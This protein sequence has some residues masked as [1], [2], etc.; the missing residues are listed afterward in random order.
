MVIINNQST[1]IEQ[2]L[3]QISNMLI[4]NGILVN[5]PG[6]LHGKT[7]VAVFFFHYAQYTGNGLFEDYALDLIV[8]IQEQI[9]LNN[10]ADYERGI[11]G[12]GIGMDYLIR[13]NFLETDN[14]F[15]EDLDQRMYRAVMYDPWQDFSLY[16]GLTGYGRYWISRMHQQASSIQ[17]RECLSYIAVRIKQKLPNIPEKELTG[18][19]CFLYD[20]QKIPGFEICIELL[21][22][23]RKQSVDV[24]KS[25]YRLGNSAIGSIIR[26]YQSRHYSGC[27]LH[28][29]IGSICEQ[30]Q[31]LDMERPPVSMGLL[32]GYA[33]EGMLRLA[34]LNQINMSWMNLL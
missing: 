9:H 19:C 30:I 10:S 33:G 14:D 8:E 29:E 12:I 16:D 3:R 22:Q 25:F 11:A 32:T 6:L 1:I 5:C 20:L 17:A 31:Y 21:E 24:C 27:A 28:D 18:V 15:F 23:C 13:N 2:Q 26:T 7:G 4:L 34:A